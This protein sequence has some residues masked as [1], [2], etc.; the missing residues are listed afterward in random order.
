[1][2]KV[3]LE[4]L[5]VA[6]NKTYAFSDADALKVIDFINGFGAEV[7]EPE[8]KAEKKAEKKVDAYDWYQHFQIDGRKVTVL[9]K[10]DDYGFNRKSKAVKYRIKEC[11]AK[12]SGN[13]DEKIFSWTF[14]NDDAVKAFKKA[15]DAGFPK[16]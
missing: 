5:I 10:Q 15:A 12:W 4:A 3:T 1:M 14:A 13:Y 8:K 9:Y 7:T 11:G 16:K 2:K 6:L